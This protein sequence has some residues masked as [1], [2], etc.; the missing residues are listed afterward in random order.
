[1]AANDRGAATPLVVGLIAATALLA[2]LLLGLGAALADAGRLA[3]TA[4][5]AA[6]AAGD[7]LLGWAAGDPCAAAERVAAANDAAVVACSVGDTSVVVTV[8]RSILLLPVECTARAG[9]PDVR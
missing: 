2:T 7:T 9:A 5:G 3:H 1:M 6:L 8:R 4:D